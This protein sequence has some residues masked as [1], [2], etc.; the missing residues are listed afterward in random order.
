MKN[1]L[2]ISAVLIAAA[3]GVGLYF[4]YFSKSID[5][6]IE[7]VAEEILKDNGIDVDFSESKKMNENSD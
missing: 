3:T 1:K 4:Q 7:Q 5:S 6:P 2:I